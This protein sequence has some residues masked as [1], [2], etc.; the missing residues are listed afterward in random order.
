[1]MKMKVV[2]APDS[3]KGSL[4]ALEVAEAMKEGILNVDR[5][6][7]I[8]TAPMADGGEGT[9]DNVIQ[10]FGGSEEYV[11]VSG[12][13]GRPVTAKYGIFKENKCVIEV[14]ESSGLTLLAPE[15]RDPLMTTTFGLGQLIKDALDKGCRTF[16]IG[17]GG[18]ATNDG[19]AGMA[20]ALGYGLLDEDGN[21]IPCCGGALDRLARITTDD[22]DERIFASDF[23]IAC[24]VKNPLCGEN[25]ASRIFG[26]QKGADDEAVKVLDKNLRH[27]ADIIYRDLGK[28]I[29]D[30]PGAGAA[31]GLGAG[32]VAFLNGRLAEGVTIIAELSELDRKIRGADLVFTGEGKCD[33]QTLNGKTPFGVAAVAGRNH[34]PVYII[35]GTVGSGVE[36][37]YDNG[38]HKIYG[39]KTAEMTMEYSQANAGKLITEA[40]ARAYEEFLREKNIKG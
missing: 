7:E 23:L 18:S 13:V 2:L 5:N 25:G 22:V 32:A 36:P 6:V 12:P 1:M 30:I 31:G 3:F 29:A 40:A 15:E 26:P 34:V 27:F 20:A 24:D 9:T 21:G 37:L 14:A 28:S 10:T 38:V 39:I 4:S 33:S 17:L 19:G 16:V 35:A 8:E 11:E